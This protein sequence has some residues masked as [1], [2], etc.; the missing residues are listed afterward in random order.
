M[1]YVWQRLLNF[2]TPT[3]YFTDISIIMGY[4]AH[5]SFISIYLESIVIP[6]HYICVDH[7]RAGG[8]I[9]SLDRIII[10]MLSYQYRESH[11]KDKR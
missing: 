4:M 7:W 5:I 1:S 11:D 10:M 2:I 9:E 3:P 6:L 8:E